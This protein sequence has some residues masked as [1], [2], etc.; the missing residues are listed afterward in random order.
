[1]RF[2]CPNPGGYTSSISVSELLFIM[3]VCVIFVDDNVPSL[4]REGFVEFLLRC[5]KSDTPPL[6]IKYSL[7]A[8]SKFASSEVGTAKIIAANGKPAIEE[9]R[10]FPHEVISNLATSVLKSLP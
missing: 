3:C 8:L 10:M 4:V 2:F 1:M 6:T 9:L 7:Q 5:L